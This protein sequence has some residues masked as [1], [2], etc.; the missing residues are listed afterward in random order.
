MKLLD[1]RLISYIIKC[2]LEDTSEDGYGIPSQELFD[3][4]SK[5]VHEEGMKHFGKKQVFY[6]YHMT[7]HEKQEKKRMALQLTAALARC[8]ARL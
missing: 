8:T 4:I 3:E 5:I 2:N 1:N 6:T 7:R